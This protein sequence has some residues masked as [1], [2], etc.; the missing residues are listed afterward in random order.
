MEIGV[1]SFDDWVRDERARYHDR[2]VEALRDLLTDGAEPADIERRIGIARRLLALDPLQEDVHRTLM[3]L[4]TRRGD[5]HLAVKQYLACRDVLRLELGLDPGF[6]TEELHRKT[7]TAPS[8]D[9]AAGPAAA[10][11]EPALEGVNG[12]AKAGQWAAQKSAILGIGELLLGDGARLGTRASRIA[13]VCQGA[14][15]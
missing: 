9:G 15:A 6:R 7:R 12:G 10:R 1:A 13:G 2:A 3:E 5:R 14:L 11:P 8:Q 4:Y